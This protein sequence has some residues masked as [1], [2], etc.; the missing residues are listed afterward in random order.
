MARRSL[1]KTVVNLSPRHY[2]TARMEVADKDE[3]FPHPILTVVPRPPQPLRVFRVKAY[4]IGYT[5]DVMRTSYG[6]IGLGANAT[7]DQLP[8]LLNGFSGEH[9]DS[10]TAYLRATIGS[11]VSQH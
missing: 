10:V 1:G 7:R 6:Q 3:L 4:T 11:G 5:L 9:P 8:V 2:L